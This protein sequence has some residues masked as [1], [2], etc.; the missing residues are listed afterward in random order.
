M[1]VPVILFVIS[2]FTESHNERSNLPAMSWVIEEAVVYLSNN[3]TIHCYLYYQSVYMYNL[4]QRA[5]WFL[6]AD[7][8]SLDFMYLIRLL[9]ESGVCK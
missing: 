1:C 2:Y 5:P 4:Q 9:L 3:K 7:S 8:F 6:K